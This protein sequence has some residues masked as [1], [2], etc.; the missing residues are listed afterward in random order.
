M[1]LSI[2]I[3]KNNKR[4]KKNIDSIYN[5]FFN[6]SYKLLSDFYEIQRKFKRINR[7]AK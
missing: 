7:T 6:I 3:K 1:I 2:K 5:Y 4:N